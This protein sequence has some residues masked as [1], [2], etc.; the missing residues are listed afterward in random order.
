MFYKEKNFLSITNL[1]TISDTPIPGREV[2]LNTMT[3]LTIPTWAQP[4]YASTKLKNTYNFADMELHKPS[5]ILEASS[6]YESVQ[7]LDITADHYPTLFMINYGYKYITVTNDRKSN[8][9]VTSNLA[10][11]RFQTLLNHFAGM[12]AYQIKK[13]MCSGYFN[14]TQNIYVKSPEIFLS[15]NGHVYSFAPAI[16]NGAID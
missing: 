13:K 4:L 12:R 7:L 15:I 14:G 10:Y 1:H 16:S 3:T 6:T 9:D 8:P 11:A 5:W 2:A